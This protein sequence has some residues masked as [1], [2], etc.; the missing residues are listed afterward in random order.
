M[1]VSPR[2]SPSRVPP[3]H[4]AQ[5]HHLFAIQMFHRCSL[6]QAKHIVALPTAVPPN[7]FS[8]RPRYQVPLQFEA[9]QYINGLLAAGLVD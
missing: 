7:A 6:E 4:K 2:P 9:E 5:L 8:L 3:S 1:I